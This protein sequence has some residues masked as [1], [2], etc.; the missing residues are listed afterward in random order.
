M[1]LL[2]SEWMFIDDIIY[3]F[4]S[5]R[6]FDESRLQFLE[7]I[8]IL[9]PCDSATFFLADK[10]KR[11]ALC[12][13]VLSDFS[14]DLAQEYIDLY[15]D[16]DYAKWLFS[17]SQGR[18]YKSSEWF[19]PGKREQEAYY[20]GYYEKCNIHYAAFLTLS[21]ND[22]FI[23]I[24]CLYRDKNWDDFT[25]RDLFIL[26]IFKKHLALKTYFQKFS[27]PFTI[28]IN[29]HNLTAVTIDSI[30]DKHHLTP[31][32]KEITKLL[33]SGIPNNE[34]SDA[35]SISESTLRTH[36]ANIYRKLKINRRSELSRVLMVMC[37]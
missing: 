14:E 17:T 12:N 23:G 33:L 8:R 31:R 36:S 4:N 22:E 6:N 16:I 28:G 29:D 32:E 37:E 3:K 24:I 1:Q 19:P 5:Q 21:Y 7:D 26:D 11:N 2:E 9:I 35:L 10:E 18:A 34:I 30:M 15:M 25:E 20:K 13:P 27:T